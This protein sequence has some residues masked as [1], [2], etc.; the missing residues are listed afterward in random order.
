MPQFSVYIN[1]ERCEL[2]DDRRFCMYPKFP[3]GTE[4]FDPT[5]IPPRPIPLSQDAE[6]L[7]VT[8]RKLIPQQ[9]YIARIPGDPAPAGLPVRFLIVHNVP[10]NVTA[11]DLGQFFEQYSQVIEA[12]ILRWPG[13]GTL[14]KGR[15]YVALQNQ[16][17]MQMLVKERMIYF[18]PMEMWLFIEPSDRNPAQPPPYHGGNVHTH[19]SFHHAPPPPPP[20]YDHP[21]PTHSHGHHHGMDGIHVKTHV[22]HRNNS[23]EAAGAPVIGHHGS[24]SSGPSNR[25]SGPSHDMDSSQGASSSGTSRSPPHYE[26]RRGPTGNSQLLLLRR[27]AAR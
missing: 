7:G 1:G 14:P 2:L 8:A 25:R 4:L 12:D 20:Q 22:G 17:A 21:G 9:H 13:S 5:T 3:E 23:I 19:G 10:A 24:S 15:G 27:Q 18:D 26:H 16:E 11:R 6:D